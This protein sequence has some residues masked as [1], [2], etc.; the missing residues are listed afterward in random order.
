VPYLRSV[1]DAPW[2]GGPHYCARSPH[3]HWTR[4]LTAEQ[5]ET[6]LNADPETAVGTLRSLQVA[7]VDG[8]GRA[9]TMRVDGT[10]GLTT[11]AQRHGGDEGGSEEKTVPA[12]APRLAPSLASAAQAAALGDSGQPGVTPQPVTRT[13]AGYAFR[14][15][16][17]PRRL[18]S[19]RFTVTQVSPTRF[20]V[21]GSGNGHGVGL[22]QIGA[23]GMA[24]PPYR[25][26]FRQILAH[27][28]RGVTVAPF[29]PKDGPQ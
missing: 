10:M 26:T 3:Q 6:A 8:S 5:V 24:L 16:V 29:R 9:K 19:T 15:A 25:C 20:R 13:M 21:T 22:C 18:R 4:L 27:Y 28:Y 11:E 1:P 12:V 14:R 7:A 23:R 17:G 2:P